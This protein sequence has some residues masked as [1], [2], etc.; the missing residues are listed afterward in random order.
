MFLKTFFETF[1]VLR[2]LL[3]TPVGAF[4]SNESVCEIMQSCFRICFE[5][6]LSELLRKSAEHT[7]ID[8][9]Q[10]LFARLPHF[11]E[12]KIPGLRKLK[13]RAGGISE[14]SRKRQPKF[15]P[16]SA[17]KKERQSAD[18]DSPSQGTGAAQ[19]Q[20][21][22]DPNQSDA[23]RKSLSEQGSQESIS[24]GLRD[25]ESIDEKVKDTESDACQENTEET[26]APD[27]RQGESQST[28]E[29]PGEEETN[30][31]QEM[32]DDPQERQVISVMTEQI[33]DESEVKAEDQSAGELIIESVSDGNEDAESGA[34]Q[35]DSA[36]Q[37]DSEYYNTQGVRFTTH[38]RDRH[39]SGPPVPYGLPCVR[40]LFRFLISLVNP[41][42]R[43][44]N[45]LMKHMG[46]SLL[47]VALE[48]GSD[49]ISASPSL[50][51]L[52]KDDMCK[53]IFAVV[54]S[55]RLPIFASA[56]RVCFLLFESMR[57]HL[58]LQLEMFLQKLMYLIAS[59]SARISYE[60]REMAV[61][62]LVQLWRIPSFVAELYINY[63]CDVY[64]SNLFEDLTK[65]LSK[66][67]FPVSGSLF[68]THLLSLDALLAVVDSIEDNC[69]HRTMSGSVNGQRGQDTVT[70]VSETDSGI[71]VRVTSEGH[72]DEQTNGDS[73]NIQF[74]VPPTSGYGMAS[75]VSSVVG[76]YMA[77]PSNSASISPV[78]F[79]FIPTDERVTI[80]T[81][82]RRISRYP[83]SLNLP[84]AEDIIALKQKKKVM[85]TGSELF[86]QKASK[87]I[88]Y[89][90]EKGILQTPMDPDEVAVFIREG[91]GLDK[92]VIGEYLSAK[93]NAKVLEAFMRTFQLEETRLDESLRMFLETF[94]LPG[95]APVIQHVLEHFAESWHTC[96]H[97]PFADSDAAFTLAYAVI[98]LN[99]DQ[100]NHNAKKQNIPM[101][102]S[103]F[104]KNLKKVNGGT[105]FSQEMLEEIYNAIKSEEIVMPAEQTGLVKENYLWRCLLK[106]GLSADAS[107]SIPQ[108]NVRQGSLPADL[109]C[110][111]GGVVLRLRQERRRR[112]YAKGPDR[113]SVSPVSLKPSS[114]YKGILKG[115]TDMTSSFENM[116]IWSRGKCAMISAHYCLTDVFDN[117]VISICKYST[118]LNSP[119]S[120]ETLAILF[121]SNPKAQL[122]AK[123]VFSLAHRHGDILGEGWKNLLD[124]M[125]Q[126][127]RAKLLPKNMIEVQ[128]FVNPKG[129]VSLI[130]EEPTAAKSDQSYLS[131][132]SV[133]MT[134]ETAQQKAPSPE[135]QEAID[136]AKS[137]I[138]DCQP[139]LLITESKFLRLESLQ[140]LVKALCFASLQDSESL[141]AALDEEAAVFNLEMLISLVLE[142]RD[143]VM[144]I[145]QTICDH[146][147]TIIVASSE[148][149][150]LVERA[151]RPAAYS[152]PSAQE[153]GHL[154]PVIGLQIE[155]CG[156]YCCVGCLGSFEYG[157]EW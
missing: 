124:C 40:E 38:Q 144:S 28:L 4:L 71:K 139:E 94:R 119:E 107:S 25:A 141:G 23:K 84:T 152:P 29:V 15:S 116:S 58:K 130:Q 74:A 52:V 18:K 11:R 62:T 87:G 85:S 127:F 75:K 96:N 113:F 22:L 27:Q 67:A 149:S 76:I 63:D 148:F 10:L 147:Y 5:T 46:L 153:G 24:D 134:A 106:R 86:N 6:R 39:G 92:K 13:M 66:N 91:P 135:D 72:T 121:G 50:L 73:S 89:L 120:P 14:P 51:S 12:E 77:M 142:N 34:E 155:Q 150:Y 104:R 114:S 69:L 101:N 100:H 157:L 99:V 79:Y 88:A 156:C 93:K 55:D 43:H 20:D 105:D 42:D 145:W 3:L 151:V 102:L 16:K 112:N 118:L 143:R 32:S 37:Q 59:E 47:T 64:C 78:L 60:Q 95:E 131:F 138:E 111:R 19:G 2:T 30:E 109:G 1:L 41:Y 44:N 9:V 8:M 48:T 57:T 140:E 115:Q 108:G 54:P 65:L 123:M 128:D 90:Q 35:S 21:E 53:N 129:T 80:G 137:C 133:F 81:R 82:T 17:K 61:D 97:H 122:A 7:L 70:F 33:I 110:H 31:D 126:L 83:P 132:L 146:L 49:H 125:L 45:E 56:L 136:N 98:M 154:G 68:T 117:L 103:E 26:G 36:S